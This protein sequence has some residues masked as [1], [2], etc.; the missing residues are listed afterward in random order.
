[1]SNWRS[2]GLTMMI[3]LIVILL[4]A[5]SVASIITDETSSATSDYYVDE[6]TN[7][8]FDEITSYIQIK[9]QKGKFS[10]INNEKRIEKIALLISPM[11]SQEI[12]LS[13][14]NIQIDNGEEVRIL[15]YN[16]SEKINFQSLFGHN[17]WDNLNG[18][19]YGLISLIDLD[20]SISNYDSINENSDN[21]YLIFKLPYSM[22]MVKYDRIIVTLFPSSGIARTT[23]LVAPLPIKS[24][25]TF[26]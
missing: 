13:L 11:I 20:D 26:E 21:A 15:T 17:L 7:E 14:L 12:D 22:T 16:N 25:I 3:L 19:N 6:F 18:D 10:G 1:M 9:D 5:I 4:L 8:I 2:S 24:I 23:V